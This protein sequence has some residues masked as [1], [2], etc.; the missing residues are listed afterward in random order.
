MTS[1]LRT[2]Q[3][4]AG[5]ALLALNLPLQ[6]MAGPTD[7]YLALGD[8]IAFGE[9]NVIPTSFADQGYVKLYADFLATRD[10]GVRPHVVNLAIPGETSTSFLTGVSP[11]GYAPHTVLDSVNLNYQSNPAQTQNSLMLSTFAS[12]A[13]AGRTITHVS[14]SLGTNDLIAFEAL[15]LDF[16][17][18]TPVQQA[19]LVSSFFATL[20]ANY[21]ATLSEI[22][23]A[24]PHAELLLLNSYNAAAIFGPTDP[25]NIVD[26]IF[27]TGQ[28]A[29][30]NSLIVPFDARLV[31]IDQ[32]FQ[33][34]EANFTFILAGDSHPNDAGYRAIADQ[35]IIAT[36]PEPASLSLFSGAIFGVFAC[37]W[38]VVSRTRRR[39]FAS[40]LVSY[41]V[42][43]D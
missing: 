3:K 19:Q 21:I 6:A 27:D 2:K 16:F 31:D 5:L 25:F 37:R 7:T 42:R 36:V 40:G 30:I 39:L 29:M 10:S 14:Y 17:T 20:T 41:R 33:G 4:I 11:P 43:L 8:S 35:M 26:K 38:N 22:R 18:L 23:A 12:E 13:A 32:A 1:F 15:H 9:T 28:T 24:L 34:H